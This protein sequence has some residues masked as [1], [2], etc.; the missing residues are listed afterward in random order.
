MAQDDNDELSLTPVYRFEYDD[1]TVRETSDPDFTSAQTV[2]P[3]SVEMLAT[4]GREDPDCE[5]VL[6]GMGG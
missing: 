4:L 3:E 6:I 2:P 1:G 5:V